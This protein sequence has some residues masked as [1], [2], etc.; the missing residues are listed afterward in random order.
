MVYRNI[1]ERMNTKFFKT[2]KQFRQWL[3]ANHTSAT[4][5]WVGFYKI[6]SAKPSITWQE[7]VDEALCFGWIDGLRKSL[8]DESYMIRFT[9]RKP[10][11]VWSSIN[12]ARVK[13]LTQQELMTPAGL[14]AFQA[15]KENKS[16]IYSYEQ[17]SAELPEP[18]A[19][20]L[21][22]NRQ[23][24]DYFHSQS[25]WYRK[26]VNWWVMSAR[27]VETQVKRLEI[28]IEYSEKGQTVPQYTRAKTVKK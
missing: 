9:P 5:L 23:A 15:R 10:Q 6:K 19:N 14:A 8:D 22:S 1:V 17:R 24:W 4:E 16:G 11:S 28:L 26:S 20:R 12:I 21:K 3:A 13:E 27:R 18:Y 25:A 2:P 7:S